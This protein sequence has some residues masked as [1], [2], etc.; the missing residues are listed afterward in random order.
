MRLYQ[1]R[2]PHLVIPVKGERPCLAWFSYWTD[3]EW[4]KYLAGEA[5]HL[6]L[7]LPWYAVYW[8]LLCLST[9]PLFK[10]WLVKLVLNNHGMLV[11]TGLSLL[12]SRHEYHRDA[13]EGEFW[14]RQNYRHREHKDLLDPLCHWYLKNTWT[15]VLFPKIILYLLHNHSI[16]LFFASS[17]LLV[18]VVF[19][20]CLMQFCRT[21]WL[22]LK[23][24]PRIFQEKTYGP[25]HMAEFQNMCCNENSASMIPCKISDSDNNTCL[26]KLFSTLSQFFYFSSLIIQICISDSRGVQF[27]GRKL[28]V[29]TQQTIF[30]EHNIFC[31]RGQ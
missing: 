31:F 16:H 2:M 26:F 11:L 28:I 9:V 30:S 19:I 27:N 14:R 25:I 1:H 3:F 18:P 5:Y 29:D 8:P 21:V 20:S 13:S 23:N 4:N 24:N 15:K 22:L 6:Y 7:T 10:F 12:G 17:C